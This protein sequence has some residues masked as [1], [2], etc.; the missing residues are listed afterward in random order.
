MK[1]ISIF[2]L[3]LILLIGLSFLTPVQADTTTFVSGFMIVNDKPNILP[4]SPVVNE[5]KVVSISQKV[6]VY[7]NSSTVDLSYYVT[8]V[9]K[10]QLNRLY[11]YTILAPTIFKTTRA[12]V[13]MWSAPRS[14]SV[15]KLRAGAIGSKVVIV[16]KTVNSSNNIWYKTNK[17][18]WI[19]SGNLV[20]AP[21]QINTNEVLH[22]ENQYAN[23][24]NVFSEQLINDP[25]NGT[26]TLASYANMMR[27]YEILYKNTTYL[28]TKKENEINSSAWGA[29]LRW[30]IPANN[31]TPAVQMYSIIGTV[32]EKKAKLISYLNTRPEGIVVYIKGYH[33]VLLTDYDPIKNEFYAYDSS[34]PSYTTPNVGRVPLSNVFKKYT[35]A[36]DKINAITQVWVVK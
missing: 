9:G 14:S 8:N 2:V 12:D 17:G 30:S 5:G 32:T 36:Y 19:Y 22:T 18:Y 23:K 21:Y 15:I 10:I 28:L 31:Y 6:I 29:G 3:S 20:I 1:K 26:C 11:P 33:A 13:P 34:Y 35:S 27:R 25:I 7:P 16:G 24:L 4:S